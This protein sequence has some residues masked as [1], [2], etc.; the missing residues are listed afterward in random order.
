MNYWQDREEK[1]TAHHHDLKSFALQ[2]CFNYCPTQF[3]HKDFSED[4]TIQACNGA[5]SA[6]DGVTYPG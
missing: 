1:K 6:V 5:G 2:L 3:D 4:L